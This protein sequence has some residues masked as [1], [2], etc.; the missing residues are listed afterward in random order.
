MKNF[1]RT[2][3]KEI[4]LLLLLFA[5]ALRTGN[6]FAALD[7]DEIWTLTY[8]SSREIRVIFTELSLPN[9]QP[10][11]SLF[12]KLLFSESLPLWCIRLHSFAAGILA[13]LLMVPIG[14]R[15]GRSR[16]SGLWSS[17]FLLF[18]APAVLYSQQARGYELQLFFLLLYAWGL[19]YSDVK[20]WQFPA[21]L[22]V[23]A[24][25]VCSILTLSTSAIY[26]G[27]ITAGFFILR[28][29]FPGK[30]LTAVLAGGIIFSALWYG[31]NFQQFRT[32]QQ[33]GS[34]ISG[35]KEFFT[36]AFNTLDR[37]IPLSWCPFLIAGMLLLPRK[38]GALLAGGIFFAL[39]TAVVTRGGGPRVYIPLVI[40]AALIC[41]AGTDMLCRKLPRYSLLIALAAVLCGAA[42]FYSS[43]GFWTPTDWYALYAC[44]KS[45][46]AHTLVIYSGTSGFPVMWNNRPGS[47]EDNTARI[48]EAEVRQMLSFTGNKLLNGVD[49][50]FNEKTLSLKT[51]GTKHDGGFLYDL[52]RISVPADGDEILLLSCGEERPVDRAVFAEIAP[53]GSF[54]RLNIFFEEQNSSGTVNVIRGG[55][56]RKA[57]LFNW[58]ALPA[59]MKLYRIKS[60][61]NTTRP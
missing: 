35:H 2:R 6:L 53:C 38:K 44:G 43:R 50:K 16:G 57:A 30:A 4:L 11:N 12:V 40:P 3:W 15:L 20:K 58:A 28:P 14:I 25:G 56:I 32:G 17:L 34:V 49:E 27:I 18:S 55:I 7:Y 60:P 1:L 41:G 19:L 46:A 52:E 48:N 59:K 33:W 10:L 22:A 47:I 31:I 29:V 9:N 26:L 37:L 8:F 5:A 61:E 13:V 45:Q 36:F 39:L 42:G 24:G 54:L 51:A 23:A 21:L